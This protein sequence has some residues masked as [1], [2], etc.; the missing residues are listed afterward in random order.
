MIYLATPY[1]HDDSRVM[2]SRFETACEVTARLMQE[3]HVVFSP[4]AHSHPI[5]ISQEL[6]RDW[7]FWKKIDEE[8]IAACEEVWVVRMDGYETS[9]G[10]QAEIHVAEN[11]GKKVRFIDP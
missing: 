11:L 8:F 1:T 4:I 10:V 2:Q 6:P 3:G 5:A 7:S 9:R